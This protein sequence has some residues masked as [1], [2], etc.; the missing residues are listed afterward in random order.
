MRVVF[1]PLFDEVTRYFYSFFSNLPADVHLRDRLA[2]KENLERVAPQATVLVFATHGE[3]DRLY[4]DDYTIALSPQNI[5]VLR[6]KI[7]IV[8]A[9]LTAQTLGRLAI[10]EGAYIYFGFRENFLMPILSLENPLDDKYARAVL[11]PFLNFSYKILTGYDVYKAFDELQKEIDKTVEEWSKSDDPFADFVIKTLLWNKEHMVLMVNEAA[12][13]GIV[14][15]QPIEQRNE[16]IP[17]LIGMILMMSH[18]IEATSQLNFI[19]SLAI[20][21]ISSLG[22]TY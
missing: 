21:A 22:G 6:G 13:P 15:A 12:R 8:I 19:V 20:L 5:G 2:N 11:Q 1:T 4:G 9:C 18:D 3:P 7:V 16:A 10:D 17:M 14:A